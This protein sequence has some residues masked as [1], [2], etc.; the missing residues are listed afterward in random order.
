MLGV[1]AYAP[2][3]STKLSGRQLMILFDD[4]TLQL[5]ILMIVHG[6]VVMILNLKLGF[7]FMTGIL[8]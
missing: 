5:D 8:N 4:G 6:L 1:C 3:R 2:P 7:L